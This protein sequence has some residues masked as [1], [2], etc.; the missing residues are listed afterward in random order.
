MKKT[1]M[2][3]LLLSFLFSCSRKT[4]VYMEDPNTGPIDTVQVHQADII[5][6]DRK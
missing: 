4:T 6:I 3:L 2:L 1:L 5:K